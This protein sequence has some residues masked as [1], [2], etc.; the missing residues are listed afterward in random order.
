[1]SF[2]RRPRYD[3]CLR[4]WLLAATLVSCV[5]TYAEPRVSVRLSGTPPDALVTVDDQVVGPLALVAKK[6]LSVSRGRHR[7]S[8]ERAG[9]FP[10]DRRLEADDGKIVLDVKLE[11]IPD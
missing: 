11:R 2:V 7:V 5:P 10:W 4:A 3:V 6:G 1:M 9:Y 8:V